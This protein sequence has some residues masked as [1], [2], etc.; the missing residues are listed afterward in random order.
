[1]RLYALQAV[2]LVTFLLLHGMARHRGVFGGLG[3]NRRGKENGMLGG[4]LF[5]F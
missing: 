1:M 2:L 4:D 5:F 3:N